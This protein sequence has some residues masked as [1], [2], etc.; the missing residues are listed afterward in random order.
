M[1][2]E[3]EKN[4]IESDLSL[5]NLSSQ[6]SRHDLGED[7]AKLKLSRYLPNVSWYYDRDDSIM[8]LIRRDASG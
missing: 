5:R 8:N 7:Q 3:A 4:L 1:R 6:W 2:Q